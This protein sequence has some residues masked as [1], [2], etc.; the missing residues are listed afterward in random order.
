MHLP[1]ENWLLLRGLSRESGHWGEFL[2]Q[3]QAAFPK[4]RIHTLDL[5][6]TGRYHTQASPDTIAAITDICRS[7]ALHQGWLDQPLTLLGLSLGGMVAWQWLKMYS[8]DVC[9]GVLVNSS[10]AQLSPFYQR[11]RWQNYFR[12]LELV[13]QRSVAA[14]EYRIVRLVSQLPAEQAQCIAAQWEQIRR[15]HPVTT[16]NTLRQLRAAASFKTDNQSPRSPVLIVN[17]QGDNLVAPACSEAISRCYRLPLR[18]HPD[19][20]HDLPLDA[21]DWLS[22]TLAA[23]C[24]SLPH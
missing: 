9:A 10:F 11:L 19:A 20:G 7:Q 5:P 1:G 13:C 21:G 3:L 16:P 8:Q 2:P 15:Q 6:G 17:S 14:Q 24:Q 12:L 22:A 23:W 4:A 18:S